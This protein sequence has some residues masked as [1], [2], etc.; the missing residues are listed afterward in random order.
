MWWQTHRCGLGPGEEKGIAIL[1]TV[2][3]FDDVELTGKLAI[4]CSK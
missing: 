3:H 2:Q 4:A 1:Q